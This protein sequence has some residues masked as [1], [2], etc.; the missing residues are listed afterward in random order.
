MFIGESLDTAK[1]CEKMLVDI[2]KR[3][4]GMGVIYDYKNEK[5]KFSFK[6]RIK[7]WINKIKKKIK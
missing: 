4:K 1:Q 2:E 7:Y 5:Y 3:L 6:G